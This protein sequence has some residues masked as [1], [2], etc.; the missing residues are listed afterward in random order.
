[1]A[2]TT[3]VSSRANVVLLVILLALRIPFLGGI[4]FITWPD[5]PVWLLPSEE[6]LTYMATAALFYNNRQRLGS[7]HMTAIA[8]G[9]ARLVV[10]TPLEWALRAMQIRV[11]L[12]LPLALLARRGEIGL[13]KDRLRALIGAAVAGTLLAVAFVLY[14]TYSETG[15]FVITDPRI[16]PPPGRRALWLVC[17]RS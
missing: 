13:G 9:A 4:R 5:Y 6:A 16:R 8:L 7:R 10:L 14:T 2:R 3:D 11:A 12:P 1:M 15:Q 17:W